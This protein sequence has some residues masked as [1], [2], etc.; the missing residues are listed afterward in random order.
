VIKSIVHQVRFLYDERENEDARTCLIDEG[1]K[2]CQGPALWVYNDAVFTDE[3][4]LTVFISFK[5]VYLR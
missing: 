2:E 5:Y 4:I 3:V 1:M